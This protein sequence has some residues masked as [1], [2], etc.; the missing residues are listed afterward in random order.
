MS[1]DFESSNKPSNLNLS[2][3]KLIVIPTYNQLIML[4]R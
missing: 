3:A 2:E 4:N 1:Q